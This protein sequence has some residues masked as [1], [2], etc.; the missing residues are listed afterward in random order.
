MSDICI[1]EW[2]RDVG[3][4]SFGDRDS[5]GRETGTGIGLG[6]LTDRVFVWNTA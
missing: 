5:W 4:G 1:M 2:I 3:W 6:D